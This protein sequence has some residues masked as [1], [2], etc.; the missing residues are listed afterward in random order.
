MKMKI[1][2]LLR[3][4]YS[5]CLKISYPLWHPVFRI[6]KVDTLSAIRH[7][8]IG[9]HNFVLVKRFDYSHLFK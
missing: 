7:I 4:E 6:L 1:E 8:F 5:M 3:I 2:F 9:L